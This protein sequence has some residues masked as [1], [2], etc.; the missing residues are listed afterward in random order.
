MRKILILFFALGSMTLAEPALS[1]CYWG[2][3]P[4]NNTYQINIPS[5]LTIKPAPVGGVLARH[6]QKVGNAEAIFCTQGDTANMTISHG[7]QPSTIPNVYQTNVPGIGIRVVASRSILGEQSDGY[8]FPG[9]FV[10]SGWQTP[11]LPTYIYVEYVRTGVA[12]GSGLVTASFTAKYILPSN[13]GLTPSVMSYISTGSTKLENN[14]YFSSCESQEPTKT[15]P[16]GKIAISNIKS[17]T[18][19][20]Q[21]FSFEVRC[22]GM[23]P[24]TPLPMKIY[25]EGDSKASGLLNLTG[26]GQAGVAQGVAIELQNDKGSKLPFNKPGAI[27]MDWQRSEIDSEVYRFSGVARYAASGGEIK[28]GKADATMTYVLDYN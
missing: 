9:Q 11:Y 2:T 7:L 4:K 12:V 17:S 21:R 3:Q 10:F 26:A 16:M 14:V 8:S 13:S 5:S 27:N 25:F 28:A 20:E 6:S 22:R 24:T 23:Q 1:Y 15:V 18:T 19:Q